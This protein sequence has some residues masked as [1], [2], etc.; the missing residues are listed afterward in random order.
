MARLERRHRR[1]P[2]SISM[3]ILKSLPFI[4]AFLHA[5]FTLLIFGAAISSPETRGL[6]PIVLYFADYPCSLVMEFLRKS[7]HGELTVTGR[8][9]VDC[10]VYLVIGSAWFFAIGTLVRMGLSRLSKQSVS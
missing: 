1:H 4:L 2:R 3:R 10:A 8:L 6:L 7:L 5:A 9:L